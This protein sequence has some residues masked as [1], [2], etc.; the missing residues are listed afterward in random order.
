MVPLRGPSFA[1]AVLWRLRR[2]RRAEPG[3]A[4]GIS[5]CPD[6]GGTSC[7][8]GGGRASAFGRL[9]DYRTGGGCLGS[10]LR[11]RRE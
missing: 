9:D 5:H 11:I 2:S 6:T 1:M 10:A 7:A 3:S 4:A 8:R